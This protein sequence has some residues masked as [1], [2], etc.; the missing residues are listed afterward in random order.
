MA[1]PTNIVNGVYRSREQRCTNTLWEMLKDVNRI[2]FL[3]CQSGTDYIFNVLQY[4]SNDNVSSYKDVDLLDFTFISYGPSRNIK[5]RSQ[6]RTHTETT[7]IQSTQ[8]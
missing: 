1:A 5:S 3:L 4:Q 8:V 2:T 7:E 6:I